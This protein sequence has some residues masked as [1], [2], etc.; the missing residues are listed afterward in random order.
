MQTFI[1]IPPL[2]HLNLVKYTVWMLCASVCVL[3]YVFSRRCHALATEGRCYGGQAA[4]ERSRG[5]RVVPSLSELSAR[6]EGSAAVWWAEEGRAQ[7]H[8]GQ[9]AA[10]ITLGVLGGGNDT[11]WSEG[12]GQ[13]VWRRKEEEKKLVN[14]TKRL[15]NS[16][17]TVGGRRE[18]DAKD[19]LFTRGTHTDGFYDI[20][21]RT[22]V[23]SYP[24]NP[25]STFLRSCKLSIELTSALLENTGHVFAP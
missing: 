5:P 22:A 24:L 2:Q 9:E 21:H 17:R 7:R 4:P 19:A 3:C 8:C 20:L 6:Q 16:A 23:L 15:R 10:P 11:H 13:C 14:L 12:G 18:R 25:R 1:F